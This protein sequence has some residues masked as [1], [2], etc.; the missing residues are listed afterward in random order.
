[1]ESTFF[2]SFLAQRRVW[3]SFFEISIEFCILFY[4]IIFRKKTNVSPIL[5]S[6]GA[7]LIKCYLGLHFQNWKSAKLNLW[8]LYVLFFLIGATVEC[9][10]NAQCFCYSIEFPISKLL[11]G[12]NSGM[13]C[14][15]ETS[16]HQPMALSGTLTW[17][18]GQPNSVLQSHITSQT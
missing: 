4:P 1:M 8:R 6:H 9:C 10:T 15:A 13:A 17:E 16:Q 5:R 3:V 12:K 2:R 14:G 18:R 7:T 11:G